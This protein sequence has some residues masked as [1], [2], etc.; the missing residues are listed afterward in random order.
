MIKN[1][2][3]IGWRS[4][5]R[6][7][8]FSVINI[9]G[10][11]IGL[12]AAYL[13]TI[14]TWD[15]YVMN[16]W[17]KNVDRHYFLESDWKE[18]RSGLEITTLAPLGRS[19]KET[20]P[21]LVANYFTVHARSCNVSNATL[22]KSFRLDL[23]VADGEFITSYGLPLIYGDSE[24]ALDDPSTV[25]IQKDVA[26]KFF[27]RTDV[28]GEELTLETENAEYDSIGRKTFVIS[29]II[30]DLSENSLTD[31]LGDRTDLYINRE[32]VP[33]YGP[34]DLWDR[35]EIDIVQTRVELQ[36]GISP[37]DLEAPMNELI[38]ENAPAHLSDFIIPKLTSFDDYNLLQ[39][40]GARKRMIHVLIAIVVF[41]LLLAL[42]NFVN[43]SLGLAQRRL[44]E[45]GIRK[46][47]GGLRKQLIIQFL[48]ESLI[49]SL[50]ACLLAMCFVQL[51]QVD[52]ARL[53]QKP[54]LFS[55]TN[56]PNL[57][58]VFGVIA[59]FI[60][61]L[62]GVYPAFIMAGKSVLNSLKGKTVS[63]ARGLSAK[64]ALVTLQFVLA[65]F[66]VIS[67]LIISRQLSHFLTR[68]LGYDSKHV[69][70]VSSLPRWWS[71][72]GVQKML[73]LKEEFKMLPH[74]QAATLSFEVHDGRYGQTFDFRRPGGSDHEFHTFPIIS[75]DE[76]YLKNFGLQLTE[77]R[78]LVAEDGTAETIKVV[79]NETAAV[80]LF[81]AQPALGQLVQ[82]RDG[83]NYQVVGI[84]K[85]FNFGS[86]HT[87][88]Q[89]YVFTHVTDPI[90]YRYFSFK[91][92]DGQSDTALDALQTKWNELFP[93]VPFEYFF[94][95]DKLEEM[96]ASERQFNSASNIA[97]VLA[98]VVMAIGLFGVAMQNM[99]SKVK[100]VGVR[101]VLGA[102]VPDIITL[103]SR[104]YFIVALLSACI[105]MP[106]VYV[107]MEK[108]L[109]DFAYRI[110][111]S[112]FIYIS[113]F[114]ILVMLV[115]ITVGAQLIKA[116][117]RN[118]ADSLRYE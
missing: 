47:M 1:Y 29:G 80:D 70:T 66:M 77:G 111:Q 82:G 33:Y 64:K 99:A 69:V 115:V 67:A 31:N 2:L 117:N 17:V 44:R 50:L 25:V 104:E 49:Y 65:L 84:V 90:L 27:G 92:N 23:Q 48:S 109:S 58:P 105:T 76:E 32:N 15:E 100:E 43:I 98:L 81:A 101:K 22:K 16:S 61:L 51:F 72:A 41:I 60:G 55:N 8:L 106:L 30:N 93:N 36:P 4:L 39:N 59:L 85:D 71:D 53:V 103:L 13:I 45:I 37:S 74:V 24:T 95:D 116:A 12:C 52:F 20:Y 5:M 62:A 75:C 113:S 11:G 10:L 54:R 73:A 63:S 38:A 19:L 97:A 26:L 87:P 18:G 110:D 114:L 7:R 118:P 79:L 46:V 42:V 78:F 57:Y 102:S 14:F 56:L 83:S 112:P 21:H 91:L 6:Q 3:K 88:I 94:M 89:G 86:L 107:T 40:N 35:W 9:F 68:D 96:Y 108:W 28:L 34:V